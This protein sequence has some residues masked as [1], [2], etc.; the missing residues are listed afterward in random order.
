MELNLTMSGEGQAGQVVEAG[1]RPRA[2]GQRMVVAVL[3]VLALAVG[4]RV[5]F[6]VVG[7]EPSPDAAE[8]LDVARHIV[9]GDGLVLSI[10]SHLAD[11][12]PVVRST[13]GNRSPIYPA[14]VAAGMRLFPSANDLTVARWVNLLL[15]T[16]GCVLCLLLFVRVFGW[17]VG[18][19]GGALVAVNPWLIVYGVGPLADP[20]SF[21]VSVAA[22]VL[23]AWNAREG[24]PPLWSLA[25][26][27]LVGLGYLARPTGMVLLAV[28][29]IGYMFGRRWRSLLWLMVGAA[30]VASPY[31]Y[32]NWRING[33]PLYNAYSY[34]YA[35]AES[36]E[37]TWF[38]L[39][40]E[41]VGPLEFIQRNPRLVGK[42]M[43]ARTREDMAVVVSQLGFLLLLIPLL[44]VGWWRRERGVI[45]GYAVANLACYCLSWAA[46][47]AW[48]YLLASYLL[49]I[50]SLLEAAA[51]PRWRLLRKAGP[52]LLAGACMLALYSAY[53][54]DKDRYQRHV[55]AA[56][57]RPAVASLREKAAQWLLRETSRDEVVASNNPWMVNYLTQRPAVICP[58]FSREG[59]VVPFLRGHQVSV[60]VLFVAGEDKRVQFLSSPR[61]AEAVRLVEQQE[62]GRWRLLVYRVE[63][64]LASAPQP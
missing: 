32:A 62:S 22:L 28:L 38:G 9:R 26:G 59:Q 36:R 29:A 45:A 11:D 37:A 46:V 21:T 27:A 51:R 14:L 1:G 31:L 44:P 7:T 13:I 54:Q 48:R 34:N 47:G 55:R 52:V 64:A 61:L 24:A 57:A 12:K 25:D 56:A 15:S 18:V 3:V 10:K 33:S 23:Y 17:V 5:P 19:L 49:P 40:R 41:P 50:P 53:L 8:Y 30:V 63:G 35:V 2:G 60:I 43:W 16:L 39:D 58:E 6:L 42:L 4:A 20:L